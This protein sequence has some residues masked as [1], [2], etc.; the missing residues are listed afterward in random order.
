MFRKKVKKAFD[1]FE[2]DIYSKRLDKNRRKKNINENLTEKDVQEY[3]YGHI[4][5]EINENLY[6]SIFDKKK[7][8]EIKVVGGKIS[9]RKVRGNN[10]ARVYKKCIKTSNKKSKKSTT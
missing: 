7:K 1:R 4:K 2:L 8:K 5:T 9:S 6:N 10:R 3:L